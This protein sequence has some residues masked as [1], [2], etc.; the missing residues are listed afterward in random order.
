MNMI[1]NKHTFFLLPMALFLFTSST[2]ALDFYENNYPLKG[3]CV[4]DIDE[5]LVFRVP[6]KAEK[7]V[8]TPEAQAVID[9]CLAE[10]FGIAITTK[11]SAYRSP[12]FLNK[13]DFGKYNKFLT[14]EEAINKNY[15]GVRNTN[16]NPIYIYH[17]HGDSH[18]IESTIANKSQAMDRIMRTYY[19]MGVGGSFI[20]KENTYLKYYLETHN[21]QLPA[22]KDLTGCLVLFDDNSDNIN[23]I[24]AYNF[25]YGVKFGA[26]HV[27]YNK[28]TK[29]GTGV[30]LQ[31]ARAAFKH[32]ET[33][34][35]P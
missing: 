32:M 34:C 22:D 28:H 11:H 1:I 12:N 4:F 16:N 10:N 6:G 3:V 21:D 15:T 27:K 2:F 31:N 13:L 23:D 20:N 29:E 17:T 33:Y 35:K 7:Y 9:L 30:T 18:T 8:Q 24:K 14:K 19:G 25:V 5:T 26:I